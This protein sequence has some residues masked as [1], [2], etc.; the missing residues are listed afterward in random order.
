MS[1]AE[2]STTRL[3]ITRKGFQAASVGPPWVSEAR[4]ERDERVRD[5]SALGGNRVCGELK[6]A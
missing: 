4:P 3:R 2:C 5:E 1:L 6:T